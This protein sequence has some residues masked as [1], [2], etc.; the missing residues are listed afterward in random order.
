MQRKTFEIINGDCKATVTVRTEDGFAA[1]DR[2]TAEVSLG[3]YEKDD[4]GNLK[5]SDREWIRRK[6]FA[7]AW[8]QSE[9]AGDLGFA[10]CETSSDSH[11]LEACY[12][13]WGRL[14]GAAVMQW[15]GAVN[16]VDTAPNDPDLVPPDKL[17]PEKKT[18][19]E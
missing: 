19:P 11:A 6:Q 18:T 2:Q 8:S 3:V 7:A 9:V 13:A 10:W 14:P 16:T 4:E 5:V 12:Q 1:I 17:N 15:L